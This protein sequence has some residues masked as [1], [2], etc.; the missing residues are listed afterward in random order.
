MNTLKV[1]E[2]LNYYDCPL[3]FTATDKNNKLYLCDWLDENSTS[4]TYRCT[5][6]EPEFLIKENNDL[7]GEVKEFLFENSEYI[8]TINTRVLD[9]N[10]EFIIG[11]ER[12]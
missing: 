6:I 7:S 8:F 2:V 11:G 9:T 3:T 5:Q 1:V 12:E 10:K 4:I